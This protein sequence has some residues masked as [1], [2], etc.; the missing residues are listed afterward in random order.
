MTCCHLRSS[1]VM[2][3]DGNV[4]T[5]RSLPFTEDSVELFE[6]FMSKGTQDPKAMRLLQRAVK[7]S[8][9][10]DQEE[11]I[12]Q[13]LLEKGAVP[14]GPGEDGS[15]EETVFDAILEAL[16]ISLGG[17]KKDSTPAAKGAK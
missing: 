16:F 2:L 3:L 10:H 11:E 17:S 12:V 7:N 5:M 14:F 4:Y 13:A 15:E 6:M 9:S 1:D 8:L